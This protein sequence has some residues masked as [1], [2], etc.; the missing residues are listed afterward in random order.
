MAPT[1]L[2][3]ESKTPKNHA[4]EIVTTMACVL[5]VD[6]DPFLRDALAG[7]AGQLGHTPVTA[8]T[9]REASAKAATHH[10]DLVLLDVIMPDGSGLDFLPELKALSDPPEVLIVTANS[11][12]DS[13]ETAIVNG[14][15][16]YL[17]KPASTDE[18]RQQIQRALRYRRERREQKASAGLGAFRRD[19]IVGEH[20]ELLEALNLAV[21]AASGAMA[22][23][24]TGETGT[25]KELFARAI[26]DNSSRRSEPFVVVDCAAIPENLVESMLFGHE[27]GAFTG[28]DRRREGLIRKAHGGTLFL[29][30]VGELPLSLQKA[31]LRVLQEHRFRPVGAARE[32]AS[33]F[34]IIAATNRDLEARA[35]QGR[36]REDLLYRLASFTI[37]LPPLRKRLPDLPL[38]VDR[39][40][41]TVVRRDNLPA[42]HV[43]ACFLKALYSHD[44]PGNVRELFNTLELALTA[45]PGVGELQ[46]A[47]LPTHIRVKAAQAKVHG[48]A[49]RD[50]EAVSRQMLKSDALPAWPTFK[51]QALAAAERTYLVRLLGSVGGDVDRAVSLSELSRSRLYTLLRKHGLRPKAD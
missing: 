35:R 17:C 11:N 30:E 43:S 41:R 19:D 5:I 10:P 36:F 8:A 37:H 6:D 38:L 15:W 14:A 34:R 40:L 24:I 27:R 44:W 45:H 18:Y 42:A 20:P 9:I 22:V 48:E 26:H 33:D 4:R 25:G 16:D 29:D 7:V 3:P 49:Q 47:H 23:M 12:E 21:R 50:L 32:V 2:R 31:F 28:A 13:A 51:H 46:P 1:A 39:I